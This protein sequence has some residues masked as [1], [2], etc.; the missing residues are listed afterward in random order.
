VHCKICDEYI[1]EGEHICYDCYEHGITV[2]NAVKLGEEQ[3][4]YIHINEFIANL[5]SEKE[6]NEIL[7]NYVYSNYTYKSKE[8]RDYLELDPSCYEDF[9][10]EEFGI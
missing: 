9:L 10:V 3:P 2:E 8:V 6:I 4:T 5:L 1:P 7:I